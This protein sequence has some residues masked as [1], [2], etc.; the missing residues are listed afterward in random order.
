MFRNGRS[1]R[2]FLLVTARRNPSEW[3]HPKGHIEDDETPEECAVREVEEEAGVRAVALQ[4][5][6]DVERVLSG[7][8]QRVR[9]FVMKTDD[10]SRP[11]EGRQSRWLPFENARNLLTVPALK[12]VLEQAEA[13]L[14]KR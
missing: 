1:G 7:D 6:P 2:E 11:G 14:R 9:Y 12:T 5:L 13:L 8:R 3:V 4:P 10:E